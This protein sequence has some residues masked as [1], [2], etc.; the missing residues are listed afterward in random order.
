MHVAAESTKLDL[1]NAILGI[2]STLR[3]V[4]VS[5]E[6]AARKITAFE[7]LVTVIDLNS[8]RPSRGR[9][10]A[11]LTV[12]ECMSDMAEAIKEV[13]DP[14]DK[15]KGFNTLLKLYRFGGEMST[16]N[17]I[18]LHFALDVACS[19]LSTLQEE[20]KVEGLGTVCA[21]MMDLASAQKWQEQPDRIG[22]A[23][24]GDARHIPGFR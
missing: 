9:D 14:A 6:S 12:S 11:M 2:I 20:L 10:A 15:I 19:E 5:S 22:L 17:Q 16:E 4:L 3:K 1:D 18:S 13:K 8:W 21:K 24:S 23:K 7:E